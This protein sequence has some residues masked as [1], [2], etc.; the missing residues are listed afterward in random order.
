MGLSVWSLVCANKANCS[1]LPLSLL[2]SLSQP[3]WLPVHHRLAAIAP[4]LMLRNYPCNTKPTKSQP[5]C[6]WAH[7]LRAL[8]LPPTRPIPS[9]AP[10]LLYPVP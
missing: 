10:V 2:L 4:S 9:Q 6:G 5:C 3:G 8:N 7:R 1:L